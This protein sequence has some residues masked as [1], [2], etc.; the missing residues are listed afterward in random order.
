MTGYQ[1]T[2]PT[3][4]TQTVYVNVEKKSNGIGI[5]GFVIALL[6]FVFCWVPILDFILWFLGALFSFIGVFKRPRGLAIAG[7]VLSF[8]G[9]IVLLAFFGTIMATA[10]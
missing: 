10:M 6:A 4:Q 3:G 7:L 2:S 8:I 5:A 9:I 1:Q